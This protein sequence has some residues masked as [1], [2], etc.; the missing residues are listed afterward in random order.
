MRFDLNARP[1]FARDAFTTFPR[2]GKNLMLF[3]CWIHCK[4]PVTAT[5]HKFV[6]IYCFL[7]EWYMASWSQPSI[8]D[9]DNTR[10]ITLHYITLH[11]LAVGNAVQTGVGVAE[12]ML[13]V[14]HLAAVVH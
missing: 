12:M 4:F 8:N 1:I 13:V 14:G 3:F 6:G 5:N 11:Y 7:Y 9:T 2:F 10:Y